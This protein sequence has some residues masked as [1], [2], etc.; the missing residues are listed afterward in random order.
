MSAIEGLLRYLRRGEKPDADRLANGQFDDQAFGDWPDDL[1]AKAMAA[2]L[3]DHPERMRAFL[4]QLSSYRPRTRGPGL[5]EAWLALTPD[6]W[7]DAQNL[8]RHPLILRIF[9]QA[10]ISR[11]ELDEARHSMH[12]LSQLA[13]GLSVDEFLGQLTLMVRSTI[14][15]FA[16][17][18]VP[19]L[20]LLSV[21]ECK[22]HEYEFVAVPFVERGR[23]PRS[24]A[25]HESWLERNRLYV[26]LTRARKGVW[27]L[28]SATRPVHPGPLT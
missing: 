4:K 1:D 14:D 2:Q 21:E 5:L 11:T 15:H 26:A 8:C 25:A 27:M 12:A 3:L 13:E 20:H 23:F 24:A 16:A 22:G 17:K 10:P 18:E 19:T 28:E 6:D 9:E 7:G